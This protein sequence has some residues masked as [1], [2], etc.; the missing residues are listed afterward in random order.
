MFLLKAQVNNPLYH[1]IMT[2]KIS[3]FIIFVLSIIN[4][5]KAQ[6][7]KSETSITNK[8]IK[9]EPEPRFFLNWQDSFDEALLK[10]K[11]EKKPILIYFTGSDWCGPCIK[12]NEKLFY[13]EKFEKLSSKKLVLYKADFPTNTDL[14]SPETKVTNEE[15]SIRYAQSSFP[16][17]IMVNEKGE[18]LGRKDGIYMYDY[19]YSFFE[20]IVNQYK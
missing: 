15:L 11:K 9:I 8:I 18:V 16:T 7:T 1:C 5:V 20:Q 6:N 14:V 13:T 10:A 19:Y 3:L 12:L 17:M 2:K 4:G